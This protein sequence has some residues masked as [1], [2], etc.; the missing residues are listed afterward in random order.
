MTAM[1]RRSVN[2]PALSAQRGTIRVHRPRRTVPWGAPPTTGVAG[3]PPET[4]GTEARG[5]VI[6][7]GMDQFAASTAGTSPTRLANE[8]RHYVESVVPG[9]RTAAAMAIAPVG[10]AGADLEV[11]RRM[12]GDPTVPPGTGPALFH[13]PTGLAARRPGVVIDLARRQVQLD[14]EGLHLTYRE[15]ELLHYLME[16]RDRTVGRTELI[17]SLWRTDDGAPSERTVDV[18][19]RRLRCKLGRMSAI[20]RTARGQG[21]RFYEHPDVTVRAAPVYTI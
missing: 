8:L 16:N 21:Y 2:T 11:V 13:V 3:P 17:E 4:R 1:P 15:F 12:L 18:H 20:V 9:S 7:V 19:V 14:G 10:T 5:F 6:Y